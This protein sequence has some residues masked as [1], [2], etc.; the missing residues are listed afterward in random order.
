LPPAFNLAGNTYWALFK[1]CSG[2]NGKVTTVQMMRSTGEPEIDELWVRTIKQ[3]EY[4]PTCVEG[5]PVTTCTPLRLKVSSN[6]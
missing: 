3:W 2:V 5:R 1:V 6:R 4:T